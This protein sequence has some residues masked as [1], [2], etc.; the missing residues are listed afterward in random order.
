MNNNFSIVKS[1]DTAGFNQVKI[2]NNLTG[3]FISIL[4]YSGARLNQANLLCNGNLIS[5]LKVQAEMEMKTNDELYNNAFLFPFAGRIEKGRYT[6]E[7]HSYQLPVNFE[8]ENNACHGFLYNEKF[9]LVEEIIEE[10]YAGIQLQYTG[11]N[12]FPGYPFQ[13]KIKVFY[14]LDRNGRVSL[15][16][17][18]ENL[19]ASRILFSSGWHPYYTFP[20]KVDDLIIEFLPLEKI[21]FGPYGIPTGNKIKFTPGKPHKIDLLK[22]E[23]DAVYK[24]CGTG[25]QHNIK[26]SSGSNGFNFSIRQQAGTGKYNYLVIYTPPDRSSI[27]VE[28]ITSNINSFNNNED[29]VILEPKCNWQSGFSFQFE[30]SR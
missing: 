6:F 27:A 3:E 21:E 8:N 17:E 7:N 15:N 19:S 12:G 4:P 26:I 25:E 16:T 24:L 23:L 9:D 30:E 5:A 18:I 29:V 20:V 13:F 28:P 22:T 11:N 10:D 2:V 1:I 14:S